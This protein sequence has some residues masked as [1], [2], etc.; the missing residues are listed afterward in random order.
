MVAPTLFPLDQTDPEAFY[1]RSISSGSCGNA[2]LLS[3][4]GTTIMI[5][6]GLGI[7]TLKKRFKELGV[8]PKTLAGIF[9]THD[10]GDHIRGLEAFAVTYSLPVYASPMVCRAFHH[11]NYLHGGLLR[12][13]ALMPIGEPVV[14]GSMEITSFEVPH[15]AT[16]NV[17]YRIK[18]PAGLF[19]LITDVGEVTPAIEETIRESNYLVFESNYDE[20]MLTT[21]SYPWYLKSRISGCNG[22]LSNSVSARTIAANYHPDLRFLAL[23]HLSGKNNSPEVALRQMSGTLLEAGI[24]PERD[25][26]LEILGRMVVSPRYKLTR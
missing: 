16:Q 6:A 8:D 11:A 3:C 12:L 21:G 25:L 19:S 5:D 14:M 22:H 2:S 13:L 26:Q 24:D 17:G 7:R 4:G 9:V 23:C 1:F 15:D 18:G 20:E 10:H